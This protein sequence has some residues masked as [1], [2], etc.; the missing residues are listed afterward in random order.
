MLTHGAQKLCNNL[1]VLL[2]AQRDPHLV[3]EAKRP[4]LTTQ[5]NMVCEI[6]ALNIPSVRTLCSY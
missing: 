4:A 5:R 3:G 2:N 1:P 6:G